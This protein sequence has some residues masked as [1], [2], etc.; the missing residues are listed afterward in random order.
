MYGDRRLPKGL[1]LE[2]RLSMGGSRRKAILFYM[3][4]VVSC[5]IV[6]CIA[7]EQTSFSAIAN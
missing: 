5:Y 4:S 6:K 1:T 3:S 2:S 7:T